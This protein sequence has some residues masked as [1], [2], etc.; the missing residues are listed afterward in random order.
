MCGGH[1]RLGLH[2]YKVRDPSPVGVALEPE[3][4]L[5]VYMHEGMHVYTQE[6]E[7]MHVRVYIRMDMFACV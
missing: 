3:S 2:I 1:A 4:R 6:H 7:G 5:C